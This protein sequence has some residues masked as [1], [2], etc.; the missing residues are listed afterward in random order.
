[1]KTFENV[2]V[3]DEVEFLN[4]NGKL[5]TALVSHVDNKR[6]SVKVLRYAEYSNKWHDKSMH[7]FIS[8]KKTSRFYNYGCAKRIVNKN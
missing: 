6:F 7:W 8:G 3:G 2:Q 4:S 1:M 5:E